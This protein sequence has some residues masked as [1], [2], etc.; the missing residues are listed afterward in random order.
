MAVLESAMTTPATPIGSVLKIAT[1]NLLRYRRRTLLTTLLIA[2][3]V[4]AVLMFVALAGSFRAMMVGQITDSMLGH[5]QVHRRGYLAA[6]DNLPLNLN[7]K[8]KMTERVDAALAT[9]TGVTATSPRLKFGAMFS[10]FTETTS[11]RVVAVIPEREAAVVPLLAGRIADGARDGAFL[12][13][14]GIL[15]PEILARGMNVKAGDEVV[16]VATNQDGSVNG[17]TF[18][19]QGILESV[20]GPGGRDGY[21]HIDDARALLRL[22][23]AEVSEIAIRLDDASRSAAVAEALGAALGDATNAQGKPVFEV[24]GW[25]GLTPFYNIAKMIDL[26]TLFIQIMLVS[27]VLISVMNVMMMAVY[28]RVREIGTIAA[29]GTQPRTILA[30]FLAEGLLLGLVGAAAGTAVSL[31]VIAILNSV[32]VAFQFGREDLLLAPTVGVGVVAVTV[33]VVVAVAV[34][35]SLQPA[36]KAARMD[37]NTALRHV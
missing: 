12:K 29:I 15:V 26:M 2:V 20:T 31:A 3:G 4:V 18:R 33:A 11:I 17:R 16:L 13:Q 6:I 35:A 1:R 32:K 30:L 34:L 21:V 19:V 37:P 10:N 25:Q 22:K 27:I 36:W 14:G 24:H 7:L 8:P 9:L 23:E 28:E 5:A